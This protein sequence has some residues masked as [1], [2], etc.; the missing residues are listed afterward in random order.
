MSDEQARSAPS[1]GARGPSVSIIVPTYKE[2]ESLP[3]LLDRLDQLR[4]KESMDLELLIMDDNSQE[5]TS[6]LIAK[7]AIPRI[8]LVVPTSDRGLRPVDADRI[9]R[10]A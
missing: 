2:A 9:R 4:V 1:S 3:L 6:E 10:A 7:K 5:G 8:C